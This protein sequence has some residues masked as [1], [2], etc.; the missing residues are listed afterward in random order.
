MATQPRQCVCVCQ[1]VRVHTRSCVCVCVCI[2]P[3]RPLL[4]GSLQQQQLV[5]QPLL[6]ERA[7]WE[8]AVWSSPGL[9]P[10]L[11]CLLFSP[12]RFPYLPPLA[13]SMRR[14]VC[15]YV[16]VCV[17]MLGCS[18]PSIQKHGW[19]ICPVHSWSSPGFEYSASSKLP[20][21][22]VFVNLWRFKRI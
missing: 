14:D 19:F 8:T 10:D 15:L 5:S 1:G 21:E 22:R 3:T 11:L 13:F 2:S 20:S 9:A 6:R 18:Q 16:C 7:C 4:S 17:D 12:T